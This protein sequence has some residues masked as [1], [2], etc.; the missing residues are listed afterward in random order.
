M[1]MM[2]RLPKECPS[3]GCCSREAICSVMTELLRQLQGQCSRLLWR[4]SLITFSWLAPG[5]DTLPN[6]IFLGSILAM[7]FISPSGILSAVS[8][9]LGCQVLLFIG[10][11]ILETGRLCSN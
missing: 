4:Y 5:N 9:H 10:G 8:G 6:A 2:F 7:Q 3:C 1:P 11:G